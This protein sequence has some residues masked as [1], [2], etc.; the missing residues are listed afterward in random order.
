MLSEAR[1]VLS[2]GGPAILV[3][4]NVPGGIG[5]SERL[6]ER[7]E[8]WIS[9]AVEM[10]S[11]CQCQDGCPACVGPIGEEGHGGKQESLALLSGLV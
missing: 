4:D 6:Y 11:E 10:I 9:K 1:S 7:Q 8:F 3:Y 2:D 5:L